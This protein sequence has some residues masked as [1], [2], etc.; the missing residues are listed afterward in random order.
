M[1][2]LLKPLAVAFLAIAAIS[3]TSCDSDDDA[4]LVIQDSAFDITVNNPNFST[5]KTALE[6]TG[7]DAALDDP[8]ATFTVF[9]PTNDAFEDF[10]EA[11]DFTTLDEIPQDVL[12]NVLRNHVLGSVNRA[13]DL[14][15]NYYK[16]LAV[17]ADGDSFDMFINT[18]DGILINNFVF[19]ELGSSDIP[20][21]NGVV[22]VVDEVITLPT[23]ATLAASNPTFSNLVTA[24]SQEQLVPAL[25]NTMT[26]GTNPAP[27]TVFAP[28]NDAFQAL[29]DADPN[30]GLNS[31]ADVL[32]LDNL[33]AILLYHVASGAAV[34]QEDITDGLV[35]DPITTGTFTINTTNGVTITD[36][37][38]NNDIEVIATNVTGSNG[39]VHAIDFVLLPE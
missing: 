16:T 23:V 26:T 28:T 20:V 4:N 34:R 2:T 33:D 24:L 3:V 37:S 8:T 17:N 1:K 27:F 18:N 38:G 30:D 6:R 35:V 25:Q 32:A 5:L 36:G 7:L 12:E 14:E 13:A 19:V 22:H 15:S 9:A 31:I 39:V 11:N 10:L 21:S 29:I